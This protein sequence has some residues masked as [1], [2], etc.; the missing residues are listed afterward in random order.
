LLLDMLASAREYRC[1]KRVLNPQVLIS[2]G[3]NNE[4][5]REMIMMIM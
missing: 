4:L 5:I 1:N 2:N 3:K